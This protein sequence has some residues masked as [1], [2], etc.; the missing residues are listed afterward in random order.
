[1]VARRGAWEIPQMNGDDAPE[2]ESRAPRKRVAFEEAEI[3]GPISVESVEEADQAL[4][5][6]RCN[7]GSDEMEEVAVR[8]TRTKRKPRQHFERHFFRC[9]QCSAE[10]VLLLDVTARWRLLGV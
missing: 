1:L 5:E 2:T 8:K 7:C 6:V 3:V 4:E 9:P 10:K